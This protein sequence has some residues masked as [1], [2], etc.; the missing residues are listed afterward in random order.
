MKG[1]KMMFRMLLAVG[2]IAFAMS[3]ASAQQDPIKA[4][5]D[6]MDSIARQDYNV[7]GRMVQGRTPYDQAKV[8]AA[9]TSLTNDAQKIPT[10]F[11]PNAPPKTKSD[12]DASPKVW[13]NKA[14]FDAKAADLL[15]ALND[16]SKSVKDVNTLKVA[17]DNINKAC[18]SCHETY[19]IKNR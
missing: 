10:V 4:R 7:L 14:D 16:N 9:L 17:F 8:E 5:K 18:D 13:Q 12:Y 15:K 11:A 1:R 2:A 6:L 3:A 19:R